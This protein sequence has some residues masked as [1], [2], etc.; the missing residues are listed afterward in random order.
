MILNS[1]VINRAEFDACASS[2]FGAHIR[3]YVHTYKQNRA[4]YTVLHVH[5]SALLIK[6]SR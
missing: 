3:I 4:E 1:G 5:F 2:S 6:G